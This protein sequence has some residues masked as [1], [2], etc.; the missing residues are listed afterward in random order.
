MRFR[1]ARLT[2]VGK[3]LLDA[4]AIF[5][6]PISSPCM[7]LQPPLIPTPCPYNC[8]NIQVM[9]LQIHPTTLIRLNGTATRA[10]RR[11]ADLKVCLI[12]CLVTLPPLTVIPSS[13]R[14]EHA[15][16]T[17]QQGFI[18]PATP[19]QQVVDED[20]YGDP[21][22]DLEAEYVGKCHEIAC[23]LSSAPPHYHRE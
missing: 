14:G 4:C 11:T 20:M 1:H 3:R 5:P 18:Q 2:L 13:T 21:N 6:P 17:I 12:L 23:Q 16:F 7:D 19:S 15:E 8:R 10:W 9:N 22:M